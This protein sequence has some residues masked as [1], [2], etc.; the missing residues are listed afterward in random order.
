MPWKEKKKLMQLEKKNNKKK[1]NQISLYITPTIF[2][3]FAHINYEKEKFTNWEENAK[4][5]VF[6]GEYK[7]GEQQEGQEG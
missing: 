7:E 2:K 6:T 5:G 1:Q 3:K 4:N